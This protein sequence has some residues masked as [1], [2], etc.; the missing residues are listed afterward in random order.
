MKETD[1]LPTILAVTTT[2][3]TMD[4]ANRLARAIV[5][6]EL[7][8][9]V[10]LDAL[11]ASVYR[12]QGKLRVE[13]EVRLTIKTAPQRLHDLRRFIEAEH[14]YDLPQFAV[15]PMHASAAYAEWVASGG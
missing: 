5:E 8:A 14:P 4:D 3:A 9:C 2:V 12:W 15:V 10:Q 6:K 11:A 7:A 13:P 1:G